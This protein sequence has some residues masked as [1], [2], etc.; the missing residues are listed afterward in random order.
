MPAQPRLPLTFLLLFAGLLGPPGTAASDESSPS[1][2]VDLTA[3][4]GLTGIDSR[5]EAGLRFAEA[6]VE[7]WDG[8]RAWVQYDDT[9][10]LDNLG[11]SRAGQ[12]APAFY[13]GGLQA[14]GA[15]NFTR[16]ELGYRRLPA[17]VDQWM[18]RGEQVVGLGGGTALKAGGWLGPRNDGRVESVIHGGVQLA[19]ASWLRVE[20]TVFHARSDLAGE[21]EIRGL[22]GAEADLADRV[23]LGA[24]VSSGRKFRPGGADGT[25]FAAYARASMP[26]AP[27]LTGQLLL[28]HERAADGP[29]ATVVALG[30][31]ARLGGRP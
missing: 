29:R 14:W 15:A 17:A 6:A 2:R 25:P 30:L 18:V 20:P 7:P 4:G 5:R 24:G 12:R 1:P 3:V 11:L 13:A 31:S 9:L 22:L 16:L 19:A 8:T 10:S 21:Q 28:S 26:I 27:Q 23:Q